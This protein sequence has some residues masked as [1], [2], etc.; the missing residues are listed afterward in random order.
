VSKP[1]R[2]SRRAEAAAARA[3]AEDGRL[4]QAERDKWLAV[5]T[6]LLRTA[7]LPWDEL[8]PRPEGL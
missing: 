7:P 8:P 1:W 2:A 5:S 4:P 3:K 6:K